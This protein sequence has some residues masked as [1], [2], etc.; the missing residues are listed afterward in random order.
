MPRPTVAVRLS[1]HGHASLERRQHQGTR[2]RT[3]HDADGGR[4]DADSRTY[5][6]S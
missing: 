4:P 2:D 6:G 3:G 5:S 1:V